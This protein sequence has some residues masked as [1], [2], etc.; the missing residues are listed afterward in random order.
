MC[1]CVCVRVCSGMH[2]AVNSSRYYEI[3][4][5]PDEFRSQSVI[6]ANYSLFSP[7]GCDIDFGLISQSELIAG[8]WAK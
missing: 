5:S 3:K 7:F 8:K 4:I 1:V 2:C 6:R